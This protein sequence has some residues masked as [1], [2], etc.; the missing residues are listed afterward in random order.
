MSIDASFGLG[1]A[2]VSGLVDAD[3][4]KVRDGRILAK[5]IST[6]RLAIAPLKEGGTGEQLLESDK[7][8][9]QT[10]TDEQI[11]KLEKTARKTEAHFGSPQDIEWCLDHGRLE[12]LPGSTRKAEK[13]ISIFRNFIGFREYPKYALMQ[14]FSVYK[15]ALKRVAAVLV[16]EGVIREKGDISYL[17]FEELRTVVGTKRLDYGIITKRKADY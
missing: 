15:A 12:K 11:R 14:R 8:N 7:Q 10:L 4:Y 17:T 3:N 13:T 6:K 1:E 5:K 9:L 2:L 16:Q